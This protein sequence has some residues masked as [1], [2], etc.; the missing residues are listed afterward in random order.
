MYIALQAREDVNNMHCTSI[1]NEVN[2]VHCTSSQKKV[3]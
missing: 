1:K 3:N 2:Y